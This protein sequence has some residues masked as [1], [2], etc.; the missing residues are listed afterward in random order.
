MSRFRMSD[1]PSLL[2]SLGVR[3]HAS[4]TLRRN[5][6]ALF[7]YYRCDRRPATDREALL[8]AIRERAPD[9]RI[10]LSRPEYAPEQA[11]MV[12]AFPKAAWYRLPAAERP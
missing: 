1:A 11:H 8:A 9:A 2:H 3:Y 7:D 6:A 4:G 12:I 10:M 5:G